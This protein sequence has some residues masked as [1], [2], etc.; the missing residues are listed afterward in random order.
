[1]SH[2]RILP[3]AIMLVDFSRDAIN[4]VSNLMKM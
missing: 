1:M 4:R 3:N 2:L